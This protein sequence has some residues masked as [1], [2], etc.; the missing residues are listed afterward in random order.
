[1]NRLSKN[2]GNLMRILELRKKECAQSSS[3]RNIVYFPYITTSRSDSLRD[4]VRGYCNH[5]MTFVSRPLNSK[6]RQSIG[7]LY[8]ICHEPMTI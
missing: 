3:H 8:K 4:E 5:C 6:E 7:N 2:M 1:M